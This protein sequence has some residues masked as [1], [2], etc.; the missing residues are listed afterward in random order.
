MLEMLVLG[1][2]QIWNR[3]LLILL[4]AKG[5]ESTLV[6]I[7]DSRAIDFIWKEKKKGRA[8]LATTIF[9]LRLSSSYERVTAA[10]Q[11]YVPRLIRH[12]YKKKKKK[13]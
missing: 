12:V 6:K 11:R 7:V 4:N 8:T 13:K 5:S 9:R 1:K 2:K 10:Q 3:V